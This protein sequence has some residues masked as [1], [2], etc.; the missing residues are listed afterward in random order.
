VHGTPLFYSPAAD[1]HACQ[2]IT[3]EYGHGG[4]PLG[5][6]VHLSAK[7]MALAMPGST[8]LAA[9]YRR[10]TQLAERAGAHDAA[11]E[12]ARISPYSYLDWVDHLVMIPDGERENRIQVLLGRYGGQVSDAPGA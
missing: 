10:A 8:R 5:G 2:D 4:A 9:D 6:H 7:F 12:L 11:L 1:D 3:C